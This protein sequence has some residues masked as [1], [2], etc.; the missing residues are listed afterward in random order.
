MRYATARTA[1]R[2]GVSHGQ[3]TIFAE[4]EVPG[5]HPVRTHLPST[6]GAGSGRCGSPWRGEDPR[7][8]RQEV[9]GAPQLAG[10]VEESLSRARARGVRRGRDGA[11]V[12]VPDCRAG[13]ACGQEGSRDCAPKKTTWARTDEHRPEGCS[14]PSGERQDPW[15]RSGCCGVAALD[16]V[17][18]PEARKGLHAEVRQPA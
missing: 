18:P 16:L 11:A 15:R 3:E 10:P 14:C 8:D 4:V 17:L 13:A 12:R 1:L 6:A 7:A 5:G 9:W 2:G